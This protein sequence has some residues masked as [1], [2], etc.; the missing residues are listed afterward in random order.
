MTGFFHLSLNRNPPGC[1]NADVPHTHA[2]HELLYCTAGE[3]GQMAEE[4]YVPLQAGDL[5]YF[6]AG[7]RHCSVFRPRRKFD[8][9][10]LDFQ[11]RMFTPALTGD[12]EAL[13]VLE[14]MAH[15]R[16]RVPLSSAGGQGVRRVLDELLAEFQRKAPAYHAVLKMMTMRLLVEIARDEEFLCQGLRVCPPPSNGDLVGEVLHYL[17]AFY[18]NEITVDGLLEFCPMSRSHFHAVFKATTGKTLVEYLTALRLEQA[19]QRLVEGDTP[20]AEIA[21]QTGFSTSSYFGQLFR[22]AHG[23]S[24]G[25]YRKRFAVPSGSSPT[26]VDR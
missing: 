11:D 21:A 6:P 8:C 2:H 20:I 12:K 7:V 16:G 9:Y 25:A 17:D 15:F 19:R 4:R 18:M 14:K 24:P 3:G 1:R 22:A 23:M 10:V 13:D 5:F 26:G